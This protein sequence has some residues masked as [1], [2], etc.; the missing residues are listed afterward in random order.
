MLWSYV[1]SY[2]VVVIVMVAVHD[3]SLC[4]HCQD[5]GNLDVDNFQLEN[6]GTFNGMQA[7]KNTKLCNLLSTYKLA[8]RLEGKKVMVNAADPGN[9]ITVTVLVN[10]RSYGKLVT[11]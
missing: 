3:I 11:L 6:P 7:Y 4:L 8:E 9:A 5:L 10:L 1:C 2:I